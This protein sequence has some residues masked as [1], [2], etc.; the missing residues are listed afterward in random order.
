[1]GYKAYQSKQSPKGAEPQ[2]KPTEST[3]E[4]KTA[5]NALLSASLGVVTYRGINPQIKE[6]T[7]RL[8]IDL[9]KT[10]TKSCELYPGKEVTNKLLR[11][12]SHLNELIQTFTTLPKH[13]DEQINILKKKLTTM[14]NAVVK[15]TEALHQNDE[16]L[17]NGSAQFIEA[18]HG[19]N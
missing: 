12:A 9:Q 18:I 8:V 6:N 17:F 7:H 4:L 19:N 13:T 1:M 5:L 10:M 11:M 15:V 16:S 2:K 3:Q 14:Q